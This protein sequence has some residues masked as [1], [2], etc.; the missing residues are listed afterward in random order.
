[1]KKKLFLR[2][3]ISSLA[4]IPFWIAPSISYIYSKAAKQSKNKSILLIAQNHVAADYQHLIY[5]HLKDEDSFIIYSA[6]EW[7]PNRELKT[8]QLEN[9][10]IGKAISTFKILF[11]W[12]DAVIFVNH[13]HGLG[14][15][16][17]PKIKKYYINHG[18]RTGKVNNP[19]NEDGAFT[20]QK[21]YDF[22]RRLRY[23]QFLLS[24]KEEHHY[25]IKNS[26]KLSEI[27]TIVGSPM[28]D[29]LIL[30]K[31]ESID[32]CAALGIEKKTTIHVSS[33]WGNYSLISE[34]GLELFDKI[35]EI[36]D[37]YNFLFSL[38]PR[39]DELSSRHLPSSRE[40]EKI[41]I[42]R[43]CLYDQGKQWKKFASVADISL[44]DHTSLAIFHAILKTPLIFSTYFMDNLVKDAPIKR[45]AAVSARFARD[46]SLLNSITQ[47][48]NNERQQRIESIVASFG[49]CTGTSGDHIL[50]FFKR[51]L[52]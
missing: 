2:D 32:F 36:G 1:M 26:V 24:N 21:L 39:W 7:L 17:L 18:I 52:L 46:E 25:L 41:A 22:P 37:Q 13:P 45:L 34:H 15:W 40:I 38:H 49:T 6:T 19:E 12:W 8:A 44:S 23:T 16:L 9:Y 51:E 31:S 5:K 20:F 33:T 35:Q 29:E 48:Q 11:R 42:D 43:G 14:R 30:M 47:A 4:L 3:F 10:D 27:S 28:L 50:D